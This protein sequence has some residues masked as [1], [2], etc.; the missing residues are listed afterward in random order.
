MV[1]LGD[2][3]AIVSPI[4]VEDAADFGASFELNELLLI[5]GFKRAAIRPLAAARTR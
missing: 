4:H 2:V 3:G 1:V 5:C